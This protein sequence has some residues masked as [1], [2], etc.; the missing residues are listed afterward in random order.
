MRLILG[1]LG[2][3]ALVFGC[4]LTV[5]PEP[6]G[7]FLNRG[8]LFTPAQ[9]RRMVRQ[10]AGLAIAFGMVVLVPVIVQR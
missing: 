5:R 3:A 4:W 1:V 6:L 7:R 9:L 8:G 10:R 2:V